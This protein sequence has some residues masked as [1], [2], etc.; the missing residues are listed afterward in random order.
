MNVFNKFIGAICA[1]VALCGG[2][3]AN[4]INGSFEDV[5]YPALVGYGSVNTFQIYPEITG[6]QTLDDTNIEIWTDNFIVEAFDGENV[7]ELNAHPASGYAYSIYQ[8]FDT[9][10][11]TDYS[12]RF[13]GQKREENSN[14]SFSVTVGDLDETITN[15]AFGE[16]TLYAFDFTASATSTRLTFTSLDPLG[17]TTGNLF[18]RVSVEFK[19]GG[20]IPEPGILVL[21]FLGLAGLLVSR[22]KSNG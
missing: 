12:L 20:E 3:Q 21:M 2:A 15:Q 19:S 22:K 9:F 8:D 14:E 17:D 10:I 18:D 11:G 4:L 6:W 7:L 13:A 1:S 16:W 5:G